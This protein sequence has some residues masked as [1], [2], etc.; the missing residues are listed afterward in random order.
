[1]A[2]ARALFCHGV[3]DDAAHLVDAARA[4]GAHKRGGG[5]VKVNLDEQPPVERAGPIRSGSG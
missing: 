3:A 1:M 4:R 5:A 2:R